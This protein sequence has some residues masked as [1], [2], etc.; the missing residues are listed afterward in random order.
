M[1]GRLAGRFVVAAGNCVDRECGIPHAS[2][3]G[4]M[5]FGDLLV[6]PAC[7]SSSTGRQVVGIHSAY[8]AYS[9][10]LPA[11][12]G[13]SRQEGGRYMLWPLTA[14]L[15]RGTYLLQR[16]GE[17]GRDGGQ[18]RSSYM[19]VH[20]SSTAGRGMQLSSNPSGRSRV[21]TSRYFFASAVRAG[22]VLFLFPLRVVGIEVGR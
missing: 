2:A 9:A 18:S 1:R 20:P 19:E 13:V 5:G 10:Y 7:G 3:A 15:Q 14:L 8:S 12:E 4:L 11:S 21:R 22:Q 16:G 17:R 6:R